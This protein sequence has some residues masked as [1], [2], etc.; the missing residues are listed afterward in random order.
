[1][2][3]YICY[4]PETL[5]GILIDPG[6]VTDEEKLMITNFVSSNAI[7]LTCIVN[8]HGH[9]DHVLGNQFAKNTFGKEIF[10][11]EDDAFLLESTR[12][13]ARFFGLEVPEPPEPD[14]NIK[15][16][17]ELKFGKSV[18]RVIKTPGHSPGSICLINDEAKSVICGD[19]IFKNSVGRTDIPGGNYKVLLSSISDKLFREVADDYQLFPGH[20]ESTVVGEEKQFNPFL[21]G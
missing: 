1:M 7:N 20:L 19:L 21:I 3:C 17:D 13:Q 14:K 15:E 6:A 12:E 10:I 2:N 5:D 16:G 8:T 11:N 9:V 4:D 18:F